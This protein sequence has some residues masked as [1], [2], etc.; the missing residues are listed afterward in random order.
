MVDVTHED[1]DGRAGLE[2]LVRIDDHRRDWSG[3]DDF[4]LVD[5]RALF[6]TLDLQH[7]PVFLAQRRDDLLF[8][9]LVR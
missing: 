7:E 2:F 9:H 1:D 5:A 8:Q 3:D 4:L 6:T